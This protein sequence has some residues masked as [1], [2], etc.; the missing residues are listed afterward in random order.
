MLDTEKSK[1]RTPGLQVEY[2]YPYLWIL[3]ISYVVFGIV[4]GR[5][6]LPQ[7]MHV[8]VPFAWGFCEPLFVSQLHKLTCRK[9][10]GRNWEQK[11]EW[12]VRMGSKV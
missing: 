1:L 6:A 4:F 12:L 2:P 5:I 11:L 10:F 8:F 7:K 9:E 3:M